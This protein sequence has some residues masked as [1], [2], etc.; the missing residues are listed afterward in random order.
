MEKDAERLDDF[1]AACTV[2]LSLHVGNV[3]CP[4]EV[5][6]MKARF[7]RSSAAMNEQLETGTVQPVRSGKTKDKSVF[8]VK[9]YW[10][11]AAIYWPEL[12]V[13]ATIALAAC[14]TQAAT[15]RTFSHEALVHTKLRNRMEND[16]TQSLGRVRWNFPR[17]AGLAVHGELSACDDLRALFQEEEVVVVDQ[18]EGVEEKKEG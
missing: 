10:T 4:A 15:E 13:V 1:K 7:Q 11:A 2:Q 5:A 12:G 8:Q 16:M 14:A 9:R 18:Q 17:I 3:P 6:G